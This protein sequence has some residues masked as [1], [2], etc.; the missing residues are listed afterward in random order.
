[1]VLL[2]ETNDTLR[3]QYA[4]LK[5]TTYGTMPRMD[6]SYAFVCIKCLNVAEFL[7]AE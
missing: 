7:E 3:A 6:E 4:C 5:S 2:C 1:M